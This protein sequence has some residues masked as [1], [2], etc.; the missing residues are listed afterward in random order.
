MRKTETDHYVVNDNLTA[1]ATDQD[2]GIDLS[3]HY[4]DTDEVLLLIYEG[5]FG[6]WRESNGYEL[7]GWEI[8]GILRRCGVHGEA[9]YNFTTWL[10]QRWREAA[11]RHDEAMAG[12]RHAVAANPHPCEALHNY[13]IDSIKAE[14]LTTQQAV[15]MQKAMKV[16]LVRE[17]DT[18]AK[19]KKAKT[20]IDSFIK[21][22][23]AEGDGRQ[24]RARRSG[25]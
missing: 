7:P 24:A 25:P 13:I 15:R 23:E 10:V 19:I 12:K 16:A 5:P 8:E 6:G 18:P 1:S 2:F 3:L 14:R 17:L 22:N 9:F 4:H 11:Q 21:A 20:M